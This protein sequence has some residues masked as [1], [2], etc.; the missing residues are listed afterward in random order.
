[1]LYFSFRTAYILNNGIMIFMY[2]LI[3]KIM[4]L[5]YIINLFVHVNVHN[6]FVQIISVCVSMYIIN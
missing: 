5:T 2:T 6:K 3:I 1:M 4:M